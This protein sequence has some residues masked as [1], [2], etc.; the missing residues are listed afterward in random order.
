MSGLAAPPVAPSLEQ[1][2]TA[3]Q[4][5]PRLP[6]RGLR[7]LLITIT[8]LLAVTALGYLAVRQYRAWTKGSEQAIPIATV[9]R[10]DISFNITSKGDLRGGNPETLMA[11]ATGGTELHITFL[12]ANG[13]PVKPGD[14]VA[15][16]DTAEQQ[17]KL[18]E[19][20]ADVAE[21]EQKILQA[22]ANR[23]A[24]REEDQYALV[25]AR[26]DLRLAELDVR[27]NP[28]LAAI[29]A[30]QNILA[31]ESAREHL[32]QVQQNLANRATTG[33]A[34]IAKEA[35]GRLKALSQAKTARENIEAM[36]LRAKRA[37]YVAVKQNP[38]TNFGY[39]GM[40]LPYLQVGDT[41]RPGMAIVEI[42]DLEHWEVAASVAEIDRGHVKPGDAVTISFVAIPGRTFRGHVSGLGGT[43]GNFW[44]RHF[45]CKVALDEHSDAMRPGMSAELVVA[46][47]ALHNALSIP[48]QALFESQGVNYVFVA[49]GKSFSRQ[50][51]K[52]VRRNETRAVVTG[53]RQGQRVAL[54]N[55][56]DRKQTK[57]A[58]VSAPPKVAAH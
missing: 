6:R 36:T 48:A 10:S 32:R 2:R 27:K 54:A 24:Q 43:V 46:T 4:P 16:F 23:D 47:D 41:V 25:K 30:R 19:A 58:P 38:N 7:K 53:L 57:A 52:L 45:E 34:G 18:K 12:A 1:P 39:M 33:D 5:P 35:A 51:V 21:A 9:Q 55:P 31:L 50:D 17:Y 13:D 40:V 11:P 44:E 28:L 3:A 49:S 14:V 56:L 22:Q 20:Q 29:T 42:P 37:G 26:N 8:V 15:R